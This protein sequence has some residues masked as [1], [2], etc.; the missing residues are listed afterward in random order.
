MPWKEC[1]VM[2]ERLRFIARLREGEKKAPPL[3]RARDLARDRIQDF[4]PQGFRG[5]VSDRSKSPRV[6]T[7]ESTT[8]SD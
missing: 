6:S 7:G 5:R 1:H 2:D 3:R 4:R 8:S